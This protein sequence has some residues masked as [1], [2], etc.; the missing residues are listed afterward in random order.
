MP[1]RVRLEADAF[2]V[3]PDRDAFAFE[4]LPDRVGNVLVLARDQPRALLDH[5]HLGAEAAE[6]LR[7]F[8]PDIAAADH[9]EVARQL[10]SATMIECCRGYRPRRCRACRALL[11]RPPTLMKISA[12]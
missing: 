7:E 9:D 1:S 8:E 4:D 2:G 5:R 12:P 6:H 3:Q 10:S 11:A